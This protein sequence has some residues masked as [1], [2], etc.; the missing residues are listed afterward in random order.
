M[1][2]A[3]VALP[4]PRMYGGTM[5]KTASRAS[6]CLAVAA[7]ATAALVPVAAEGAKPKVKLPKGGSYS[8]STV[9][10]RAITLYVSGKSVQ[11]AAFSFACRGADGRTSLN[12]IKLVKTRK[13]YKF[14]V[15]AHGNVSFSDGRPDENAKVNITGRFATGGAKA[16]GAFR[17]KSLHCPDTGSIHWR[18]K[19]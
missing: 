11:L 10:G 1:A 17:V 2:R 8:G 18:V 13:G 16:T 4:P 19:R 3:A 6:F 14:A 15:K 7:A 5:R 9:K 12:D